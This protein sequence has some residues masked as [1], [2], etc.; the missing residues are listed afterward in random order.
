MI[1]RKTN[2]SAVAL[3][4]GLAFALPAVL[5]GCTQQAGE[6]GAGTE[7]EEMATETPM[8][9][10]TMAA[11]TTAKD[12]KFPADHILVQH[13]LVGF[14]GSVPGKNITRTQAEA[15]ALARDI[16]GRAQG[17]EDFGGLVQQYTDDA[18]P[19]IYGLSNTG[20]TPGANEYPRDGMVKGFSDVAFS[21]R[22]GEVGV[23]NYDKQTSPYGWHVIKRVD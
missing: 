13:V 12:E 1:V 8:E 4:F 10:E 21:L 16:L 19:G 6:E 15:E 7:T 2:W 20:V 18:Y 3:T 17:G 11:D 14:Q 22:T 5:A 23:A 9:G